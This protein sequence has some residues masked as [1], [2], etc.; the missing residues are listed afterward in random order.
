MK[1]YHNQLAQTL[2]QQKHSVWLVF[3]DEIWQKNDAIVQ[4]KNVAQ[5]QGFS[6]LIRFHADEKLDYQVLINE[7]S[8]LSLFASQRIIEV[9]FSSA[10]QNESATKS[11]Q[12]LV[13]LL[14]SDTL[15][16]FHGP[17]LD[18]KTTNKSWFKKMS[19]AGVYLPVYDLEGQAIY[20]WLQQ[21]TRQ[22]NIKLDQQAQQLLVE[23][24][25]GNLP[26]LHQELQKLRILYANDVIS[27][28]LVESLLIKQAKFTP[29]QLIDALLKGDLT[30]CCTIIDQLHQEGGHIAQLIW[31]I[32][33]ELT[34]LNT[35]IT[36]LNQGEAKSSLYSKYRIWDKRKP[37]YEHALTTIKTSHVQL[38]IARL[39][40]L[41]TVSKS[42]SEFDPFLL[43]K[44][45]IISVYH[46][47]KTKH[48]SLDVI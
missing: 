4:I 9:E 16:I 18:A 3:G 19:S 42:T 13:E 21:Q 31:L 48:F 39:A 37:L 36:A 29:F 30:R 28:D 33:K 43:L 27:L 35:M 47:D 10:K 8:A 45:T 23:S 6:E 7:M 41:D 5:Q 40:S 44:D 25:E 1:I 24:F 14:N 11:L 20:R 34:Q 32:H 2:S 26:S 12:Q 38:A 15:L 22:L 46:G 17:R